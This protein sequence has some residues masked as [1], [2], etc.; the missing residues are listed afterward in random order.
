MSTDSTELTF[1]RCHSCRSLVPAVSTRCRMCGAALDAA[2]KSEGSAEM[3][4][5]KS[6]RVRQRTMS[7]PQTPLAEAA[8]EIRR[9]DA[10]EEPMESEAG[11]VDPLSAYIEEVDIHEE[12][13]E[14]E[15][16][17]SEPAVSSES[18]GHEMAAEEL[19]VAA[20]LEPEPE[21]SMMIE[22]EESFESPAALIE[23]APA[24]SPEPQQARPKVILESGSRR[25]GRGLQFGSKA[26][27]AG[28]EAP[29]AKPAF[30]APPKASAPVETPREEPQRRVEPEPLPA[31]RR[32]EERAAPKPQQINAEGVLCGWLVS[33][34]T[35]KGESVELRSG[36]FFVTGAAL[37]PNDLLLQDPSVSTPHALAKVDAGSLIVRDLMS[38]QGVSV[39]RRG[40]NSFER[41]DDEVILEHGDSVRFG[42]VEYLVC[43]VA[44][45]G[46]E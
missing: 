11:A 17:M 45:V 41:C 13:L 35:A 23:E 31:Q 33:Y 28:P 22:P 9:A 42:Q 7:T 16:G 25:Q 5:R 1:V 26:K 46:I 36:K 20:P 34:K 4:P 8:D 37:K 27:E 40:R 39:K 43:L 3:D 44:H 14:A 38:E 32:S 6:G 30:S 10:V 21:S 24:P 18:N 15:V 2:A 19:D 29:S 12:T